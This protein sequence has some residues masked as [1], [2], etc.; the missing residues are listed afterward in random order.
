MP[1]IPL[2]APVDAFEGFWSSNLPEN[3]LSLI[4]TNRQPTLII[5]NAGRFSLHD[6]LKLQFNDP[7]FQ[8]YNLIAF[9]LPGWPGTKAPLLRQQADK[10]DEWVGAAI[11]GDFC[12]A[13]NLT[14]VHFLSVTYWSSRILPRFA[15]LFPSIPISLSFNSALAD[16]SSVQ[17]FP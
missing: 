9:E 15:A 5:L 6:Y 8:H 7:A 1:H 4:A 16:E 10:Y 13:M 17:S 3:D 12:L 11:L 2:S 14:S